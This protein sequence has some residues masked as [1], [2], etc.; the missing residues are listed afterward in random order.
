MF[1]P[2][3]R[4][5]AQKWL[6]GQMDDETY[7]INLY[8]AYMGDEHDRHK[9]GFTSATLR[10]SLRDAAEWDTVKPFDW[11]PVAGMNAAKDWWVGATEAIR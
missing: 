8:G 7:M 2:D 4:A 10:K 3:L 6:M 9:F 1:V 5:L 11:R